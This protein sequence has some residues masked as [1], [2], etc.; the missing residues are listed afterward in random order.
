MDGLQILELIRTESLTVKSIV[1]TQ[2]DPQK[3]SIVYAQMDPD[4][5]MKIL[6]ELSR[7]DYLPKDYIF[8]VAN[9]LKRKKRDSPK[10]NTEALPGSKSL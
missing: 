3:R 9:A 4:A 2:C 10:L 8:N 7:I 5:R 1:L 6:G